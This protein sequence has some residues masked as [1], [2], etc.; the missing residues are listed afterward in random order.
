MQ[1]LSLVFTTWSSWINVVGKKSNAKGSRKSKGFSPDFKTSSKAATTRLKPTPDRKK[2]VMKSWSHEVMKRKTS[3][4]QKKVFECFW[5]CSKVK[6]YS[7]YFQPSK[8]IILQSIYID[9]KRDAVCACLRQAAGSMLCALWSFS[10]NAV[11]LALLFR[12]PVVRVQSGVKGGLARTAC[13]NT[14][15]KEIWCCDTMVWFLLSSL[16][17]FWQHSMSLRDWQRSDSTWNSKRNDN[18]IPRWQGLA[19]PEIF[20]TGLWHVRHI[21][22][23]C[24]KESMQLF[25]KTLLLID[26]APSSAGVRNCQ[27]WH[28]QVFDSGQ[29]F[30]KNAFLLRIR[31]PVV[32]DAFL[33]ETS[34]PEAAQQDRCWSHFNHHS[35][36]L[37]VVHKIPYTQGAQ[38]NL[39]KSQMYNTLVCSS[40]RKMN[41]LEQTNAH[42]NVVSTVHQRLD[43]AIHQP[44]QTTAFHPK[45]PQKHVKSQRSC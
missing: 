45:P 30:P 22:T 40:Q 10:T 33:P 9:A 6:E 34:V 15:L 43:P 5:T 21:R 24:F 25:N 16:F 1:I 4:K 31:H 44:M 32:H 14:V 42:E 13:Q 41:Q 19:L 8:A 29:A 28:L 26:F 23:M 20:C 18:L 3:G 2:E 17:H 38:P 11:S 35:S 12:A 36:A 27:S 7:K 39:G 37:I